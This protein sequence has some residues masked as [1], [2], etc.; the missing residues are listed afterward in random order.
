M[1]HINEI[2]LDFEPRKNVLSK[3]PVVPDE[4]EMSEFESAFLCGL[5]NKF[6]PKKILEVGV[7][8]GGTTAIILQCMKNIGD[9]SKTQ[10]GGYKIM[11]CILSTFLLF[12][13]A[14]KVNHLV[15]CLNL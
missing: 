14:I 1:Y 8:A 3:I 6:Q 10:G 9:K 4:P 11:K 7:A 12:I 15:L 13:I 2:V 5:L